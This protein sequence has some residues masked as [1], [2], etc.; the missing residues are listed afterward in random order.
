LGNMNPGDSY[1]RTV[2]VTKI[3]PSSANLYMTWDW[4][5]G[6]PG[7]GELGSLFEQLDLE[8]WE[9]DRDGNRIRLIYEGKM[10]GA[11]QFGEDLTEEEIDLL[12]IA[13]VEQNDVLYLEFTVSLPGPETGNEYQGS[14]LETKLVFYTSCSDTPPPPPP[15]PPGPPTP[16]VPPTP[17]TPPPTTPVPPTTPPV[18]PTPPT[19]P[20]TP[21]PPSPTPEPDPDEIEAGPEDPEVSPVDPEPEDEPQLILVEPEP[22]RTA[23]PLPRTDGASL[24]ILA[25]GGLLI[26]IGLV[27][28]KGAQGKAE[29]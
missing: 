16:P 23:P 18:T 17:P 26:T 27:I 10:P 7:L 19:P 6:I 28:R 11:P 22:P 12:W 20:S 24:T 5:R 21:T 29:A 15:P 4:V 14:W 2:T 25:L 3:G 9:T 13:F 8:I 1:T